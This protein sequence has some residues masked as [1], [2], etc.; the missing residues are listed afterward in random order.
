MLCNSSGMSCRCDACLLR[1]CTMYAVQQLSW[2][3]V[4]GEAASQTQ[5]HHS[6][7][8]RQCSQHRVQMYLSTSGGLARLTMSHRQVL[9][10]V[11]SAS[12]IAVERSV[13][14]TQ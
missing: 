11:A 1:A 12:Y 13:L 3:S 9:V 5:R 4:Q 6:V 14:V 10:P 8:G 2:P 7:Q